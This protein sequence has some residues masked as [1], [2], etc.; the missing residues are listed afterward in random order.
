MSQS[1]IEQ[2]IAQVELTKQQA[3]KIIDL[4][5]KARELAHNPIFKELVLDG[6][7]MNEAARLA[8]LSSDPI[9]NDKQREDTIRDIQGIGS[10]KRY[11]RTI[12]MMA[13]NAR[14]E[15]ENSIETL[16]E[17]RSEEGA[18]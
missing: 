7:F 11:L 8:H 18:E 16:A 14:V 9:L 2:E 6:Y 13:D 5:D 10:F 12:T 15:L 4:G 1:E 17:L 3:E